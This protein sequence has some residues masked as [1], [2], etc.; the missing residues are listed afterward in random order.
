MQQNFHGP[1]AQI[2]KNLS[3]L[4]IES[5][6]PPHDRAWPWINVHHHALKNKYHLSLKIRLLRFHP[7]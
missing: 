2:Y 6:K 5:L 1:A 7:A 4:T 3:L